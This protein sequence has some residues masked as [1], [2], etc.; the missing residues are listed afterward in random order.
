[1]SEAHGRNGWN[2]KPCLSLASD[3]WTAYAIT[4]NQTNLAEMVSKQCLGYCSTA[5]WRK[6]T[7]AAQSPMFL[8]Q[9]APIHVISR[10][11]QVF[12]GMQPEVPAGWPVEK[13][14]VGTCW[15]IGMRKSPNPNIPTESN[16][17]EFNISQ[18]GA[19]GTHEAILF[20][21]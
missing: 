18:P 3:W 10:L 9:V 5:S 13:W 14:R 17:S 2:F 7:S 19:T 20:V 8:L 11:R 4:L 21:R 6:R 12:Q 1:M 15:N 16:S